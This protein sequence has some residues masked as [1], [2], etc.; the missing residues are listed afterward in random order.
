MQD[1]FLMGNQAMAYAA[2]LSGVHIAA[3]Y[4][5][6]PSTEIIETLARI[7]D[8]SVYIEWSTN[9]KAAL[10]VAAGASLGGARTLVTMKQV[11]LNVALD[12]LMSLSYLGIKGGMVIIVAD[13]PGPIS[14]QTEQDTRTFGQMSKVPVLDP[15]T[16]EEAFAFVI[17][18][19]ELSERY[20]TPVFVRPTTRV[21]H[22]YAQ[23][24]LPEKKHQD[25]KG[26]TKDPRWVIF[27]A[28][29]YKAHKAIEERNDALSLDFSHDACNSIEGEGTLG[30]I[31]SGMAYAYAKELVVRFGLRAQIL[32]I[33]TPFPFPDERV[34]DFLGSVSQA[35]VFEELDPFVE[36]NVAR[37][38]GMHKIQTPV[39]GKLTG[40]VPRAGELSEEILKEILR[41][42]S[43]EFDETLSRDS[44]L[45]TADEMAK[46]LALTSPLPVRPPSL[47]AGCPHRG[48]F[49]IV[50]R[51]AKGKKAVFSGDIG[52]YTL[53]NSQP[54]DM[55]D[56]CLCMGAGITMAQGLHR[57]EPDA[58]NI[59]FIGDSTFFASGIT[60][61]INAVYNQT[62]ITVIIVD[63]D[64]TAMTGG[65]P[66]PGTAHTM[67]NNTSEH[68]DIEEILKALH[69]SFVK[70]ANPFAIVESKEIVKEALETPGVSAVIFKAPC[71]QLFK[72]KE[73]M[74]VDLEACTGCLRCVLQLGCPAI[75]LEGAKI[76]IDEN[77]CN[78]CGLCQ[79]VCP[80]N[81]LIITK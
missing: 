34:Q 15:S 47:C 57:A 19:F 5:G 56:T 42:E 78:G 35:F 11:G 16:P 53:G 37:V 81:A 3:G 21:C 24:S 27:P 80:S 79:Q 55:V 43:A 39:Y 70:K 71:V 33:S 25:I 50:K 52:C 13:D 51:A 76:A 66:H 72:A 29:S 31:A 59:A 69:V 58:Y 26:F 36:R 23:I 48:S 6:T 7:K 8:D 63:N 4:P 64:T 77:V 45:Q 2:Y 32:K 38:K 9:E 67:M 14:S 68:L 10:E 40:H 44:K 49:Y 62:N 22:G 65:Q 54:L 60:G 17:K 73:R 28:L 61:V 75:T 74:V 1:K 12:P 41:N 18:A 46:D 20:Q 30:I